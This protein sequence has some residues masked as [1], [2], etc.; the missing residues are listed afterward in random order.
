[1]FLIPAIPTLRFRFNPTL[2]LRVNNIIEDKKLAFD[3][4]GDYHGLYSMFWTG[5][6]TLC[7]TLLHVFLLNL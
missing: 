4:M 3:R 6:W 5:N 1:M 2:I 7:Y